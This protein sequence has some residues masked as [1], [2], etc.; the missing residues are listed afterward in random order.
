MWCMLTDSV[1]LLTQSK[2]KCRL[3]LWLVMFVMYVV[4]P[5]A[6]T[7]TLMLDSVDVSSFLRSDG[8]IRVRA[9][10]GIKTV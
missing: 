1:L 9:Y 7:S 2:F 4:G 8:Q 10:D 6:A 3:T 5:V